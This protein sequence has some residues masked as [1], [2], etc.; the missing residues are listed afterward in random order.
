M[1][2]RGLDAQTTKDRL[3][4]SEG[5]LHAYAAQLEQA[6]REFDVS[7]RELLSE[8][9]ER[10]ARVAMHSTELEA[11]RNE[12]RRGKLLAQLGPNADSV[13]RAEARAYAS[14]LVA[15]RAQAAHYQRLAEQLEQRNATLAEDLSEQQIAFHDTRN[16]ARELRDSV[17]AQEAQEAAADTDAE[18]WGQPGHGDDDD[19]EF[20]YRGEGPIYSDGR[21]TPATSRA[22]AAEVPMFSLAP[23]SSAS[24][25]GSPRVALAAGAAAKEPS[26]L[27]RMLS[28][29]TAHTSQLTAT[30]A[31][32]AQVSASNVG[33][34]HGML[35]RLSDAASDARTTLR[36]DRPKLTAADP[37]ALLLELKSF[38]LYMNDRRL[39]ER[40]HWFS[41]A[42]SRAVAQQLFSRA[43]SSTSSV[44]RTAIRRRCAP[45]TGPCGI[46][47]GRVLNDDSSSRQGSTTPA[48]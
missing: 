18:W 42:R 30:V 16:A 28:Q 20:S 15:S 38:R 24:A 11:A 40:Y 7:R 36:P 34:Q 5:Q 39:P 46:A 17:R 35:E 3:E 33:V 13:S 8:V 41:G 9:A 2:V 14:E 31:G 19:N 23:L 32:L 26:E 45:R 47:F 48:R 21:I 29:L 27:E 43:R 37:G 1:R 10:D 25:L 4:H 12:V 6:E 44:Q 22:A